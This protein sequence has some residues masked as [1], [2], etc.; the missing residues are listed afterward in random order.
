[1]LSLSRRLRLARLALRWERMA[2]GLTALASLVALF[3]TFA[4]SGGA[5]LLPGWLHALILAGFAAVALGLLIHLIRLPEPSEAEAA[6]RLE[7]DSKVSHRP[8]AAL[9]DR[10]ADGDAALWQLHRQRMEAQA[11]TLRPGWPDPVLP[12]RDPYALRFAALRTAD[13]RS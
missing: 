11:K 9:A 2:P 1:M 7:R 10:A 13:T 4:L 8:L 6:R 3:L 12:A 5:T